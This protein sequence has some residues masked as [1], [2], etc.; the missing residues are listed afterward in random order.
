[1][2][3]INKFNKRIRFLLCVF[4]YIFSKYTWVVPLKNE[5][6]VTFFNAFQNILDYSKRNQIKYGYIKKV[7]FRT[8]Q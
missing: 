7:N 1:M 8:D 3:L 5:K 2:Q 4:Y 6:G